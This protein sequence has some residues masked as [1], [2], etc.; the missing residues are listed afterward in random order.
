MNILSPIIGIS[1]PFSIVSILYIN[2]IMD[3][4]AGLM[5]SGEPILDRYMHER[6]VKRNDNILTSYI[7]SAIGTGAVFITIGSVILLKDIGGI[8]TAMTPEGIDIDLY[9]KSAMFAFFIY[10]ILFN[11][12]NTRSENFNLFEHIK[13][14]KRFIYIL[15]ALF[16]IQTVI[17]EIG[18]SVFGITTLNAKTLC[19]AVVM[20]FLIIPVD[21]IRK[22]IVKSI[23]K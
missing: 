14:N 15:C 23:K 10:A 4:L 20:G 21:M 6:P 12:L 8:M 11:A 13:D 2:L 17:I 7:K 16:V 18:G 1:E 9:R 5:Y 19:L 22:A 3:T